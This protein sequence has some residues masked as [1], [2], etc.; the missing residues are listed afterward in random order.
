MERS[1]TVTGTGT[2]FVT[3]DSAVVRVSATHRA[4]GVAE[5]CAGVDSAVRQMGETARALVDGQDIATTDLNVWP[6][7][8][9]EG[10]PVGFEARH[11]L[12]IRVSSI[13]DAGRLIAALADAVGD[14]LQV[15]GVAMAVSE[16]GPAQVAARS[17][18]YADARTRAEQLAAMGRAVL[19]DVVAISEG[20]SPAQPTAEY[21]G[22]ALR[23]MAVR[24]MEMEAGQQ[25]IGVSL[26]V[27]WALI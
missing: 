4:A 3:P 15:D 1:V 18:A 12:A 23:A 6:A 8:D 14:R 13:T 11:G 21:G 25:A 7:H 22:G 10:R 20:V 17:A 24:D 27:T 26:T 2:T 5:A 9:N 16:P 19:G